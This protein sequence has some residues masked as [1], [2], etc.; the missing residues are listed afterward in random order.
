MRRLD[1][2]NLRFLQSATGCLIGRIQFELADLATGNCLCPHR[3]G[4]RAMRRKKAGR[5]NQNTDRA[6]NI[7]RSIHHDLRQIRPRVIRRIPRRLDV[8]INSADR[9]SRRR[10]TT[11]SPRDRG[12]SSKS[13][14][15]PVCPSSFHDPQNWSLHQFAARPPPRG[16]WPP[17][18]PASGDQLQFQQGALNTGW[19]CQIS[20]PKPTRHST[21]REAPK[22]CN[23][24]PGLRGSHLQF[25]EHNEPLI[26]HYLKLGGFNLSVEIGRARP[27]SGQFSIDIARR[28]ACSGCCGL[29]GGAGWAAPSIRPIGSPVQTPPRRR[30]LSG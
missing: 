5:I 4:S 2:R 16:N 23:Q 3:R 30:T 19:L 17:S 1:R 7:R 29:C 18:V 21:S 28:P 6:F 15:V 27:D 13:L 25:C 11:Q 20:L 22:R 14:T 26:V 8:L 24:V 9:I 10:R 12:G